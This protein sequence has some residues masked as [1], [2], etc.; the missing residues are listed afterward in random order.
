VL[1]AVGHDK[2]ACRTWLYQVRLSPTGRPGPVRPAAIRS[3][4]GILPEPAFA[5]AA[6]GSAITFAAYFCNGSGRLEVHRLRGGGSAGWAM[7]GGDQFGSL[8]VSSGGA[9]VSVSGLE[10]AGTGPGPSIRERPATAVLPTRPAKEPL[11]GQGIITRRAGVAALSPNG[12]ALYTCTV[13]GKRKVLR[14]YDVATRALRQTV[15]RWT[16][17]CSFA[18]DPTGSY[19]LISTVTGQFGRIDLRTGRLTLLPGSS[20]PYP[21]MLAW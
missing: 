4:H 9:A 3:F 19:A 12:K 6:D 11:D 10:Y 5:A 2:G 16:G 21:A 18:L 20:A 1:L 8:S 14:R 17:S 7:N 15:A 13:Q